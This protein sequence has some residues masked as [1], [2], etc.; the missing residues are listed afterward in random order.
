MIDL[1]PLDVRK[2]KE[3]FRRAV[4]GYDPAQVD[5]FLS[6]VADRLEELVG[7]Q[8]DLNREVDSLREQLARFQER[9]RALN[10]ALLAAQEL[11][12]EARSQADRDAAVRL[13]EA[14]THAEAILLDADQAIRHSQRRL[15]ELRARRTHFIRSV[16]S[17]LD[18]FTD[19]VQLEET[20]LET[21]PEDLADLLEKLE[22]D[23]ESETAVFA[24]AAESALPDVEVELPD[25][26]VALPEVEV[27]LP[28]A[29]G[30]LPKV[31]VGLPDG[32]ASDAETEIELPD[33]PAPTSDEPESRGE[34]ESPGT[35]ARLSQAETGGPGSRNGQPAAE[36]QAPASATDRPR[37]AD[38][39]I[40]PDTAD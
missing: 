22:A 14:E 29:E 39:A 16:R 10:E 17:L 9:E 35:E 12:E 38:A 26:E 8:R 30:A 2:K 27:G 5:S 28:E 37:A 3:D 36:R 20:R 13:R 31:D 6:I 33:H 32:S 1:T 11:R 7:T 21:E 40:R 24:A 15:E 4:R 34:S 25:V 19:Y 18:R 23:L